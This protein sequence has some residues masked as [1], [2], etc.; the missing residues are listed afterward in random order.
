M[1]H[2]RRPCVATEAQLAARL[3]PLFRAKSHWFVAR[4]LRPWLAAGAFVAVAQHLPAGGELALW[5]LPGLGVA[6]VLIALPKDRVSARQVLDGLGSAGGLEANR[7]EEELA[8]GRDLL[9][10]SATTEVAL[11]AAHEL[12]A[13]LAGRRKRRRKRR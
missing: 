6:C 3:G 5:P 10:L 1:S 12:E 13:L 11:A 2:P 7:L 9:T 4:A 8:A